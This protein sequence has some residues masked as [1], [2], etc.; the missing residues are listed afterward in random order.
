M[1]NRL[2]FT[3]FSTLALCAGSVQADHPPGGGTGGSSVYVLQRQSQQLVNVVRAYGM[4]YSVQDACMRFDQSVDQLANCSGGGFPFFSGRENHDPVIGV[5]GHG[6]PGHGGG[7]VIISPLPP[8]HSG[9][10]QRFLNQARRDFQIV[11][12]FLYDAN[13]DYPQVYRQYL[14]TRQALQNVSLN[15]GGNPFPG[16]GQ[17]YVCV[18]VDNGWEEHG[19]GHRGYGR[20]IEMAQRAAMFECQNYHGACRLQRCDIAR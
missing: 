12:R 4:S 14:A 15:E 5:P 10:C 3:V 2:L 18:A 13:Y 20:N 11:D 9:Q 16:G 7:P 19:G 6:H 1:R 17:N 8:N